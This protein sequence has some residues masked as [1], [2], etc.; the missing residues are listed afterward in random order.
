[1][2]DGGN[3]ASFQRSLDTFF[4]GYVTGTR[5]YDAVRNPSNNDVYVIQGTLIYNCVV[6][7]NTIVTST[8][9]CLITKRINRI[10]KFNVFTFNIR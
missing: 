3:I 9:A 6:L 7:F 2:F 4:P 8:L 1:M 5:I 10:C